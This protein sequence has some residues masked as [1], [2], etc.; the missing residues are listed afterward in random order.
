MYYVRYCTFDWRTYTNATVWLKKMPMWLKCFIRQQCPVS[1]RAEFRQFC[2][3]KPLWNTIYS[4]FPLYTFCLNLHF[5]PRIS[6]FVVVRLNSCG[7]LCLCSLISRERIHCS[8]IVFW[9]SVRFLIIFLKVST[10]WRDGGVLYFDIAD[11][12]ACESQWIPDLEKFVV[13]HYNCFMTICIALISWCIRYWLQ[14]QSV[15]L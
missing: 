5:L 2:F 9:W 7:F 12:R 3:T 10:S 15:L 4:V 11:M 8:A 6:C 1:S 14:S 13:E